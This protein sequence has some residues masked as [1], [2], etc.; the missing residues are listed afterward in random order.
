MS[1]KEPLTVDFSNSFSHLLV[2][3]QR[4]LG[5]LHRHQGSGRPSNVRGAHAGSGR[6]ST[7]DPSPVQP[8][9][10]QQLLNASRGWGYGLGGKPGPGL[11]STSLCGVQVT[12][13]TPICRIFAPHLP[14][15]W[16]LHGCAGPIWRSCFLILSAGTCVLQP[17]PTCG[18]RP[19]GRR[20]LLPRHLRLLSLPGPALVLGP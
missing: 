1:T 7:P 9:S 11:L 17:Q 20:P 14:C 12:P 13:E 15:S 3:P 10:Q 19:P 4:A 18:H 5:S 2:M 8:L 6:G 16:G